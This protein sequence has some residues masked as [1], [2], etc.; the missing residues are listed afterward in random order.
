MNRQQLTLSL[1]FVFALFVNG[2]TQSFMIIG[3]YERQEKSFSIWDYRPGFDSITAKTVASLSLETRIYLLYKSS[4][5]PYD[6]MGIL[7]KIAYFGGNTDSIVFKGGEYESVGLGKFGPL[8][9]YVNNAGLTSRCLVAFDPLPGI[10]SVDQTLPTQIG[11]ILNQ[12]IYRPRIKLDLN[13]I[14]TDG[15]GDAWISEVVLNQNPGL[16]ATSITDTV[17]K[18]LGVTQVHFVAPIFQDNQDK[19]VKLSQLMR[20]VDAG[21]AIVAS[22]PSTHS[23]SHVLDTLA[24]QISRL[25]GGMSE[26]YQVYRIAVSPLDNGS[27][28]SS[29]SQ[30]FR[31]YTN[32]IIRNKTVIIPAFGT[33]YDIEAKELIEMLLPDYQVTQISAKQ[34]NEEYNL[35]SDYA[36]SIIPFQI[37][38]LIHQPIR[39]VLPYTE[40]LD[41]RVRPIGYN[42]ADSMFMFYRKNSD[43]TF[44]KKRLLPGCPS[45]IGFF[46]NLTPGDTISYYL[47]TWTNLYQ[48][49]VP[50]TATEGYYT[51]SMDGYTGEKEM[52]DSQTELYPNPTNGNF[53][54]KFNER[55]SF[56]VEISIFNPDGKLI[57]KKTI[58]QR[59]NE[60]KISIQPESG[61]YIIQI[62]TKESSSNLKLLINR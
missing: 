58:S 29:A 13:D 36:S 6:T 50:L 52:A 35:L 43:S 41:F 38:R 31:S 34:L 12:P 40:T 23:E 18:Y 1:A 42:Y 26:K 59:K 24:S 14:V 22:L 57:L 32:L 44:I 15:V 3:D 25:I 27:Y 61:L 20:F 10:S 17:R 55:N 2:F 46:E 62:Q 37:G 16:T 30:A 9:L 49:T 33:S 51:F 28:P 8:S 56:P 11:A 45:F 39:G 47:S 54:I 19:Y 48:I 21:T 53:V 5:V 4:G 7:S 60:E